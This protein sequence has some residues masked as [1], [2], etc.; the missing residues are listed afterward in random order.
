MI[1]V[2]AN[3]AGSMRSIDAQTFARSEL[4]KKLSGLSI[5]WR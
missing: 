2:R 4:W 5:S 3:D 1:I